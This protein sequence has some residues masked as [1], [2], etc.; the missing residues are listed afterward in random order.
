MIGMLTFHWAD[1]YGAMLQAYAL[2]RCLESFDAGKVEVIPYAPIKLTGRYWLLPVIGIETDRKIRY[3][4][5][6][7]GFI[8]NVSHFGTFLRR[9]KNMRCFRRMYLTREPAVRR[10]CRLS[11]KKYTHVFIGSD[12]VWNPEITV[13]LDDAYIGNIGEKGNCRL[14]AYGASFGKDFL[15]GKY[16]EDFE[17]AVNMN[18]SD[19]SMREKSAAPFVKAFFHRHI[20][21][22]LDPTFLL[23]SKEWKRIARPPKQKGYILYIFTEY[24]ALMHQYLHDLSVKLGKKV[25]QVTMPWIGRR[26]D[27]I[28]LEAKSGPSEYIGFFQKADYVVTNSFHGAAFSVLME[29][30]F[31]VFSHSNKNAR[32]ENLLERFDLRSRL[33]ERGEIPSEEKMLRDIDW[34][35]VGRLMEK[36]RES[37]AEFIKKGL[38][39][40]KNSAMTRRFR[41]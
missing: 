35:H 23:T 8:R 21:D 4:P 12:Q 27:W 24:N 40:T 13:G 26:E 6:S 37:S 2:K 41:N 38:S 19:I 36:E 18:F 15:P 33:V 14:I 28:R 9:R 5:G 32:I 31:L 30:K 22:V 11:L 17:S 16:Q 20:A 3:F 7:N 25:I 29:K 10:A 1:D 39:I 34:E